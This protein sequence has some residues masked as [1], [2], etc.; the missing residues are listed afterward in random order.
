MCHDEIHSK[1]VPSLCWGFVDWQDKGTDGL[2]CVFFFFFKAG[3]LYKGTSRVAIVKKRLGPKWL[4]VHQEMWKSSLRELSRLCKWELLRKKVL[5]WG[6]EKQQP[7]RWEFRRDAGTTAGGGDVIHG[8]ISSCMEKSA[9]T[10]DGESY[11]QQP[12]QTSIVQVFLTEGFSQHATAM[13]TSL[14]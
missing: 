1:K 6:L 3:R 13:L 11:W 10:Q 2:Y 7:D 14:C 4:A 8:R 12:G 5:W 9:F